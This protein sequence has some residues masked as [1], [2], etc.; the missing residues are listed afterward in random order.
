M[1]SLLCG[2]PHL[3]EEYLLNHGGNQSEMVIYTFEKEKLTK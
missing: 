1:G 2:F 3:F